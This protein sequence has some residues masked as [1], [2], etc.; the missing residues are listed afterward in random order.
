MG[1][2]TFDLDLNYFSGGLE[3]KTSGLSFY[4]NGQFT[5]YFTFSHSKPQVDLIPGDYQFWVSLT[6][7]IQ[8]FKYRIVMYLYDRPKIENY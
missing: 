2:G 8:P 1:F 5:N 3:N 7:G 6:E 4:R